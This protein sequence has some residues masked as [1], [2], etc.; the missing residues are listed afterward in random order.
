M[1]LHMN[2]FKKYT[3]SN[4]KNKIRVHFAGLFFFK[5]EKT[6]FLNTS[7]KISWSSASLGTH[8]NDLIIVLISLK[9]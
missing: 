7:A 5:L 1:L 2:F 8:P 3:Q 4:L 6:L 9:I